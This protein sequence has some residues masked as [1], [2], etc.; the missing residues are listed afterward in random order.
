MFCIKALLHSGL[1]ARMQKR[2]V[3][4]S[5]ACP[6]VA[7][8]VEYV[9]GHWQRPTWQGRFAGSGAAGAAD[10]GLVVAWLLLERATEPGGASS[11]PPADAGALGRLACGRLVGMLWV[12]ERLLHER[13]RCFCDTCSWWWL[14]SPWS[15]ILAGIWGTRSGHS[16]SC[17]SAGTPQRIVPHLELRKPCKAVSALQ[18][19][20][21]RGNETG[22]ADMRG[23]SAI[24]IK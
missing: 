22:C 11:A 24:T 8:Q 14:G 4:E 10:D 16:W 19:Q 6:F 15:W 12:S 17:L 23:E 2:G 7:R 21:A 9:R 18:I 20:D 13:W 3:V 5:S 1:G